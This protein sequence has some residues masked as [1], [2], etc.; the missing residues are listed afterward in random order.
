MSIQKTPR[1]AV[2]D[3]MVR[4]RMKRVTSQEHLLQVIEELGARARRSLVKAAGD[5]GNSF[6]AGRYA[7]YVQAIQLLLDTDYAQAKALVD[8]GWL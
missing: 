4:Q 2:A 6:R 1:S 5:G 7:G 3:S 8:E